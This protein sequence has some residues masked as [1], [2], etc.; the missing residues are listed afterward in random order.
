MAPPEGRPPGL[1][2]ATTAGSSKFEIAVAGEKL[3]AQ[4]PNTGD[5]RKFETVALGRVRVANAG[6]CK[7]TIKPVRGQWS[8]INLCS[9][10]LKP[11]KWT[12]GAS[13]VKRETLLHHAPAPRG[14]TFVCSDA[15]RR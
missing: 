7:L 2:R 6:D 3:S 1:S 10:V 12:R 14:G 11:A 15:V 8:P 9:I 13:C 5:Y 4:A